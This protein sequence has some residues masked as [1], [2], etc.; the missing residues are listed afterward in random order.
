MSENLSKTRKKG[1]SHKP[2]ALW[3]EKGTMYTLHWEY[4]FLSRSFDFGDKPYSD[5][6]ELGLNMLV[7]IW[8]NPELRCY[9]FKCEDFVPKYYNADDQFEFVSL[10]ISDESSLML[11]RLS[12]GFRKLGW[13]YSRR[14]ICIMA[15]DFLKYL[16][17]RDD[18]VFS[19]SYHFDINYQSDRDSKWA[20]LSSVLAEKELALFPSITVSPV[21]SDD[22]E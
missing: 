4:Q 13:I 12:G 21:E 3:L 19:I 14:T 15:I 9:R 6:V 20:A 1:N 22:E 10:N 8:T 5:L 2:E 16:I 7:E 18:S 17:K 11:N